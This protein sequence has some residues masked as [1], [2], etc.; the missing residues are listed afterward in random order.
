MKDLATPPSPQLP[1]KEVFDN[2]KCRKS[3]RVY[4]YINNIFLYICQLRDNAEKKKN[5]RSLKPFNKTK[6]FAEE[7]K[8]LACCC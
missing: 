2:S 5:D 7:I 4:L 8:P 6:T 3:K 1:Q